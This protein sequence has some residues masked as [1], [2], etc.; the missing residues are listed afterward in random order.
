MRYLLM[1][2]LL[3]SPFELSAKTPD[4]LLGNIRGNKIVARYFEESPE[5]YE[6]RLPFVYQIVNEKKKLS[7]ILAFKPYGDQDLTGKVSVRYGSYK[8]AIEIPNN[9]VVLILD[10]LK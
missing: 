10:K 6:G 3:A 2:L 8:R 1:T 4:K 5:G 9:E 7:A